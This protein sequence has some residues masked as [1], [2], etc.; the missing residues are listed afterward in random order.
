MMDFSSLVHAAFGFAAL[1]CF[2]HGF[3]CSVFGLIVLLL[4]MSANFSLRLA[5]FRPC[6]GD[7]PLPKPKGWTPTLFSLGAGL[8]V[9]CASFAYSF[10]YL[11][12]FL[13]ICLFMTL[14]FYISQK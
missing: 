4:F 10:F 1:I 11:F 7:Q 12:V 2:A 14:F 9:L 13:L 8:W 6:E 5:E 3:A